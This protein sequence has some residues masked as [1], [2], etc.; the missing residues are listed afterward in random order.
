[1]TVDANQVV[2]LAPLSDAG[3][4]SWLR[5]HLNQSGLESGYL[6]QHNGATPAVNYGK[7][8]SGSI[9]VWDTVDKIF[10]PYAGAQATN[11]SGS[12]NDVVC[13][14]VKNLRVGDVV[15]LIDGSDDSTVLADA[16]TIDAI[17]TATKT[18]TLSGAAFAVAPEDYL[19]P[20][21]A[22]KAT[23]F[24]IVHG[25]AWTYAG[26]DHD[27]EPIHRVGKVE[28]VTRGTVVEAGLH[29]VNTRVKS[30]LANFFRFL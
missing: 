14:S 24:G 29:G 25:N 26:K 10:R 7:V 11:T 16:R 19:V 20:D 22:T 6:A 21:V 27:G 4:S 12:T 2:A 23:A 8:E 17:N 30:Q 5:G 18:V 1:M 15:E 28:F 13:N 3:N 9:V